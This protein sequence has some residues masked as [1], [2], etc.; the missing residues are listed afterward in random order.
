MKITDVKT[1]IITTP[2]TEVL[3]AAYGMRDR[4]DIVVIQVETD[5]GI[6]GCGESTGMFQET[7]QTIVETEFK[8]LL[9]GQDPT[10]IEYLNHRVA[11][12]FQWNSFAAYPWSGLDT[13]F[14]DIKG[15]VLGVPVYELLGG[16][17]RREVTC[18]GVI[19]IKSPKEDARLAVE[20]GERW[21][22]K[23]LKFKVGRDPK[24]DE[25]RLRAVREAVGPD[26]RIRLDANMAWTP[27]T[28]VRL[29][30]RWAK[31]D[32]EYV[33]QPVPA[34]DFRGL[35]AIAQAVDVPLCADESCQT[36][37]DM[38]RLAED[39]S[40]EVC[41]V[42]VSEAGGLTRLTELV[43][44]ANT[45][46][47]HCVLGTWGEL[48]VGFSA[49]MHLAAASRNFR[50]ANDQ[51]YH[52]IKEDY[53]TEPLSFKDGKITVRDKPGLGVVPDPERMKRMR[54]GVGR[55]RVFDDEPGSRFIPL[56][57]ELQL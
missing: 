10:Q 29:I 51:A 9:V 14:Y 49:G 26:V 41:C 56:Y 31:Y 40:C 15:K 13:A 5:E 35:K 23:T 43:A 55:D 2:L 25:E 8:P 54:G 33:E 44:V 53:V 36:P 20:Y 11:H 12:V 57:R 27:R 42:Y 47:I 28:A 22:F 48:G 38:L 52:V 45:A 1:S 7:A 18:S 17:Y 39:G 46:G 34:W 50:L 16:L 19:H 21:G 3:R 32:L 4:L 37:Q 24:E 6:T 30:N